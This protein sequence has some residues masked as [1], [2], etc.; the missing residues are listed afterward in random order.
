MVGLI[1][2][3]CPAHALVFAEMYISALVLCMALVFEDPGSG[4]FDPKDGELAMSR[5]DS[6]SLYCEFFGS[7]TLYSLKGQL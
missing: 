7:L 3:I 4:V 5:G 6:S 1:V 2:C